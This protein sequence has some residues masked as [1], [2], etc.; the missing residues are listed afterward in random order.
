VAGQSSLGFS[1]DGGA[2]TKAQLSSPIGIAVDA[3]G[4]ILTAD[5]SNNRIR[6]V[7]G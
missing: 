2:G 1:G 4:N 3:A 7:K 6:E 5:L